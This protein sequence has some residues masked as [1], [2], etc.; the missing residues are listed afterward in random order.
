V[1]DSLVADGSKFL[2][3]ARAKISGQERRSHGSFMRLS[4]ARHRSLKFKGHWGY[5]KV[6]DFATSMTF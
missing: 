3:A 2:E 1:F 5:Q 4:F 6:L